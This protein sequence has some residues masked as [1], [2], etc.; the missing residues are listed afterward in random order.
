MPKQ[1]MTNVHYLD[2]TTNR[3]S[4][5]AEEEARMGEE[6][7]VLGIRT[8]KFVPQTHSLGKS[9]TVKTPVSSSIKQK[10]RNINLGLPS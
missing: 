8:N 1:R 6:I 10:D 2:R 5:L 7:I 3:K 9:L 4:N